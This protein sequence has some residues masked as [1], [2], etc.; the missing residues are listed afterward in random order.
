MRVRFADRNPTNETLAQSAG[1][2]TSRFGGC[3]AVE[4]DCKGAVMTWVMC[5]AMVL[6]LSTTGSGPRV[7][8]GRA[9]TSYKEA[10]Q[11]HIDDWRRFG[12]DRAYGVRKLVCLSRGNYW[13]ASHWVAP[14][15][16]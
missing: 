13:V 7:R 15:A 16:G 11:G 10:G 3:H 14:G 4:G 8:L 2:G 1:G 5:G 9:Q 6:A 12:A